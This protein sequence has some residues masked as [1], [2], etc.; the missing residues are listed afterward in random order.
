MQKIKELMLKMPF[1]AE[2][3]VIDTP[4]P[5]GTVFFVQ[6]EIEGSAQMWS[7]FPSAMAATLPKHHTLIRA[8]CAASEGERE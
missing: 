8:V 6:T 1:Y 7:L 5:T 3:Q 4:P 2:K